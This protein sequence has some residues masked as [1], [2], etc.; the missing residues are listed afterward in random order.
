[1]RKSI[2]Q[3]LALIGTLHITD[4]AMATIFGDDNRRQAT[5]DENPLYRRVGVITREDHIYDGTAWLSGECLMT[6]SDE[7]KGLSKWYVHN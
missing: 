1:M 3:L 5:A 6:A 4:P 7:R 2:L